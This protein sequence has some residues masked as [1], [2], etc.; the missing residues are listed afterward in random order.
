MIDPA[1]RCAMPIG[2]RGHPLPLVLKDAIKYKAVNR[3]DRTA[4]NVLPY[5]VARERIHDFPVG[6]DLFW[7]VEVA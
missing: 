5:L 7:Q 2:W 3:N 1:G 6:D 4:Q